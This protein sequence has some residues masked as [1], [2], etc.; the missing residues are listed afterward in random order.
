M[1]LC[2]I[3]FFAFVVYCENQWRIS[4]G[5]VF[6]S[7][8]STVC[9]PEVLGSV[10]L[11]TRL[12]ATGLC[13]FGFVRLPNVGKSSCL[14]GLSGKKQIA[15]SSSSGKTHGFQ[16]HFLKVCGYTLNLIDSP[17]LVFLMLNASIKWY[18]ER[19]VLD[20]VLEIDSLSNTKSFAI[21]IWFLC[22][23]KVLEF[24]E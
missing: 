4:F 11:K 3:R 18:F 21:L 6:T 13:N 17:G 12:A 14:N 16:N 19:F 20:G 9:I 7:N 8:T 23:A 2:G 15:V 10:D 22:D 1:F 5:F 24:L